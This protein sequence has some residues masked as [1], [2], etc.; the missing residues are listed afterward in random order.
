M[1]GMLMKKIFSLHVNLYVCF[2]DVLNVILFFVGPLFLEMYGINL[3]DVVK[4]KG[5]FP[6][7]GIEKKMFLCKRKEVFENEMFVGI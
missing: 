6:K 4:I 5:A 1:I 3:L 2:R 7:G